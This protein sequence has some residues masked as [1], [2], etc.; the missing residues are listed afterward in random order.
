[1]TVTEKSHLRTEARARRVNLAAAMPGFARAIAVYA[2]ALSLAPGS[3][4]GGYHALPGEADPALLL[5]ALAARGHTIAYPRVV[6][7]DA[8][9][10]FHTVPAG[11]ALRTGAYGIAEPAAD[12]PRAVPGLLLV[13]LLAYDNQGHRLGYGGGFYDRTLAALNGA[14]LR[15]TAIGVAFSGQEV[16]SLP[17]G[18]HDMALHGIL[19]EH[20]LKRFA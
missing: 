12:F 9:L 18:P 1:M 16:I 13:P 7:K 6:A 10:D 2:D 20:G 5:A 11:Q 19:T 14:A 15:V 4:V 3:I 17:T 8:A